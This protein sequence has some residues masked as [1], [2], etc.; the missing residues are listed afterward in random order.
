MRESND[1]MV[2]TSVLLKRVTQPTDSAID[3]ARRSIDPRLGRLAEGVQR[4]AERRIEDRQR[5]LGIDS[6]PPGP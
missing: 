4:A 5:D 6:A 1:P 2:I 3:V